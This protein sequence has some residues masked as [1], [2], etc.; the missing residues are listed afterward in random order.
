[1]NI[2]L[3]DVPME[4]DHSATGLLENYSMSK[5]QGLAA[6]RSTGMIFLDVLERG[7]AP[8]VCAWHQLL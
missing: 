6:L 1:M 7:L 4:E 5:R 3:E 2:E 8:E